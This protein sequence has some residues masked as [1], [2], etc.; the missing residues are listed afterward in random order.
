MKRIIVMS[1][2]LLLLIASCDS[3]I[4]N[5]SKPQ[6]SQQLAQPAVAPPKI[7][8]SVQPVQPDTARQ[9]IWQQFKKQNGK[10]WRVRWNKHTG[11]PVSLFSGLSEKAYTGDARQAARDFL[12]DYRSLFGFAN[13]KH[14]KYVKTQ[15][16]RGVRHVTFNES[17]AGIP[18]YEAEFKVH[19]RP[20]GRVDMAN[21]T[22][23]PNIEVSTSPSVSESEAERMV[24]SDLGLAPE[25]TLQ[26]TATLVVYRKD[27][28]FHLVWKVILFSKQ[29][30]VDWIYMV[31]AHSGEILYKLSQLTDVTGDGDVYP[32]YP[33]ISSVAN[34]PLYRLNGYGSLEGV[35]VDVVND[36][37]SEAYSSSNSFQY[38]SSNTHFDEVNLYYQIDHFRHNFIDGVDD[39][40]L[41]LNQITAHAHTPIQDLDGDEDL[42]PNS[43]FSRDTHELYFNDAYSPASTYDFAK[44]DK[45]IQHEYSHAV[46][47]DIESGIQSER[48]SEEG[49]I[50][51]GTPDYFA[52]SFTGRA[53][54]GNYAFPLAIRDMAGPTYSDYSQLLDGSGNYNISDPHLGGEFFSSILWD[55]RNSLGATDTDFLVYDALH[56]VTG[57]PYFLDFR[58]AMMA[59]DD[60]AYS[61]AHNDLIQDAFAAKGV[62][63][64][65][66]LHVSISGPNAIDQGESGTWTASV[67][68]GSGN[69]T[70]E[71]YW[72]YVSSNTWHAAGGNSDTYTDSHGDP[73]FIRVDVTDVLPKTGSTTKNIY[74][75]GGCPHPELGC[76]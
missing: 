53:M 9:A 47:Y 19:L 21:G 15:T 26:S 49:A 11:L 42:D 76:G 13:L 73:F 51:E 6:E 70:Y 5:S 64:Y 72:K 7:S 18:V 10:G 66:P 3:P 44:E 14:L 23:Y 27:E 50:S 33:G 8:Y 57:N 65:S 28:Q 41:G 68:N 58:D 4:S 38:S 25:T 67:T 62:G 22:Y 63:V 55:I 56:R 36:A 71:W 75:R 12:T 30:G 45:I 69:Y 35:N 43:W 37:A 61:G 74:V 52:G 17:V 39:G 59:A 24:Q 32:T 29:A 1:S 60:E 46:I 2:F 20:D 31:D 48:Y 40:G 54:I 34:K 16:Y